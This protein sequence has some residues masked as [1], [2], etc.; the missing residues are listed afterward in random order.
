MLLV[1]SETKPNAKGRIAPPT[2][3]M[4]IKDEPV[5]VWTPRPVI[6]SEKIVGNIIDIKND[7]PMSAYIVIKPLKKTAANVRAMQIKV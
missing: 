6:P 7:T 2:I 4:T 5:L 3:A 1:K